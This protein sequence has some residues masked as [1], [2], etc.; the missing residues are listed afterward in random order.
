METR[1][2]K[3]PPPKADMLER[4]I[5]Y[6][7]EKRE[8]IKRSIQDLQQQNAENDDFQ[9]LLRRELRQPQGKPTN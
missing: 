8:S 3:R 2:A 4:D 1:R 9:N 6:C 5:E 7:D